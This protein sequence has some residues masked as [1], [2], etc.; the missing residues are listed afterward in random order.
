MVEVTKAWGTVLKSC[1][2][3]R[4]RTTD[5]VELL[6]QH[7]NVRLELMNTRLGKR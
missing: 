5:L 2:I 6:S 3:R 4:L 1:S 7:Q